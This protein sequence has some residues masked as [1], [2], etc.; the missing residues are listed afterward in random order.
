MYSEKARSSFA[1]KQRIVNKNIGNQ[2][3]NF[4]SLCYKIKSDG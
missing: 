1:L 4:R 2:G 3:S